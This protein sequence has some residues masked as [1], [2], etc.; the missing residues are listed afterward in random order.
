M[1]GA[2]TDPELRAARYRAAIDL[3][4]YADKNG[5]TGV[6]FEEHHC[7]DNGWLPSPLTMASAAAVRTERVQIGVM[8]LL[9]ALYDPVR[10]AED[11]AVIDL[12][13][14]GR[15]VFIA[16]MGYREVEFHAANKPWV[17]RGEWMDHVL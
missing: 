13:S 16:G 3:C 2:E 11:I 4:E 15:L 8:A 12:L 5:F 17:S 10:L 14:K 9:V 6:N 7:A 1:T